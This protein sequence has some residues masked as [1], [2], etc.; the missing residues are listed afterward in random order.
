MLGS[1]EYYWLEKELEQIH[2]TRESYV[3][4]LI[5]PVTLALKKRTGCKKGARNV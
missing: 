3:L 5:A 2:G 4:D 1:Y